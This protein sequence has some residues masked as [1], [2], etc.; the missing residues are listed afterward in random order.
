MRIRSAIPASL[1]RH[2]LVECGHK[3]AVTGCGHPA[4][5][6]HHIVPWAQCQKHEYR[7]MI[8]LCP[9]HHTQTH[10][11][12][13]DRQALRIYKSRA[14]AK[15]GGI[16]SELPPNARWYMDTLVEL[17]PVYPAFEVDLEFRVSWNLIWSP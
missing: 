13:I 14:A 17:E 7:N 11:G 1:K 10:R 16:P 2:L 3:C 6:F 15:H 5:E 8:A 12:D 9:N 4:V